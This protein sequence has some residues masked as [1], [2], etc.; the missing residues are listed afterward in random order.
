MKLAYVQKNGAFSVGYLVVNSLLQEVLG[1]CME[2]FYL[3]ESRYKAEPAFYI[4]ADPAVDI[5]FW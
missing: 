4:A 2:W 5:L 3:D 1:K